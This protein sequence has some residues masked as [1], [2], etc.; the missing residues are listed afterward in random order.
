MSQIVHGYAGTLTARTRPVR[1]A[2]GFVGAHA[3]SGGTAPPVGSCPVV[4][5]LQ[6][7]PVALGVA[8]MRSG[9]TAHTRPE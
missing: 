8:L 1:T 7:H 2:P 5:I 9:P 6:R 3:R 4:T